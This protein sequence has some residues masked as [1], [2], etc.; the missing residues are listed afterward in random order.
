MAMVKVCRKK[1]GLCDEAMP[2]D[3][4]HPTNA[5]HNNQHH[6]QRDEEEEEDDDDEEE[7]VV[8]G[9]KNRKSRKN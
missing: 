5:H 1:C 7:V 2:I 8:V 9:E 6:N 3:P 4:D